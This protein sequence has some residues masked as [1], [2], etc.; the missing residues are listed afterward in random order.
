[1]ETLI[2]EKVQIKPGKLFI[3]GK[4]VDS[5]SG[6]IFATINPATAEVIT[7][8]YEASEKDVDLAVQSA[9]KALEGPWKKMS[10]S[11]RGK[12]LWKIGD[13][14]LK[15]AEELAYLETLDSGKTI[16]ESSKIDIPHTADVFH[17]YA[18]WADKIQGE[19]IPV[20]GNFF[21]YT[22]R[23]PVGVVGQIIP[24][25][26]PLSLASWK[27]AP[28]LACGNTVILKPAEQTPLT[29]LKLGEIC[30]EAGVPDG[31]VNVLTGH[32]PTTGAALVKHPGVDKIA[33]TGSYITGQEI[34]RT[35]STTLKKVSLE[36][37]GKSPNIVFA[38]SDIEPAIR[39][40]LNGIF[41]NKGEVCS[42]G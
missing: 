14:I 28:A 34:M 16:F 40:T 36:L 29:A 15:Y 2:K 38:D 5:V 19:T 30:Q 9:R 10:A 24:W 17:Y 39:G 18:G 26:F 33:F 37:G 7:Q 41:Y 13:L 4:W 22:L 35:A 25:N 23:E 21:N 20:K 42:A 6:K 3:G 12:I 27:V 31:V 1:M 8:V 32:G 11:D